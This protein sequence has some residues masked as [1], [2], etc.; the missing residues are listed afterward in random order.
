MLTL[1]RVLADRLRRERVRI[2]VQDENTAF[3]RRV[4]A[5]PRFFSKPTT[6][7]LVKRPGPAWPFAVCVDED[8]TYQGGNQELVQMFAKG[9]CEHG[10]RVIFLGRAGD[11]DLQPVTEEALR[12]LGFDGREPAY[13]VAVAS[14]PGRQGLLS[15]FGED[16]TRAL[17]SG[18][19]D[20]CAGRADLI[21]EI[22]RSLWLER[23]PLL[24]LVGAA[25]VGKTNLLHG[26]AGRLHARRPESRVV[27]VDAA[28][29]VA[30]TLLG[31]ER[32]Q[33]TARL[34]RE[35][36]E[37]TRTILAIERLELVHRDAPHTAP[38]LANALDRGL[39]LVATVTAVESL[40]P[41]GSL[42]G[43][44]ME[45]VVVPELSLAAVPAALA[46]H[47]SRVERHHGVSIHD[48]V[49]DA[50]VDAACA[51]DGPWPAKAVTLMDRSAADAAFA[52]RAAV[53]VGDVCG[54]LRGLVS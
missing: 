40:I 49:L 7:L 6:N 28:A 45:V 2:D 23:P 16:L 20:P 47:R 33:L 36:G 1:E 30:G 5:N 38:L 19:A 53:T 44:R 31:A 29:L 25:G 12:V 26:V 37:S 39:R 11:H 3:F 46:A 50:V 14:P 8:L 42:L 22:C 52:G 34:L 9:H 54:R 24:V 15:T 35:V 10:W 4:P 18:V 13:E 27:R 48:S 21:D 32:E 41:V 43:R 17:A 51:I